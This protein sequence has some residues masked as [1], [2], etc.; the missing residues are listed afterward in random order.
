MKLQN[1]DY[2]G[3]NQ[4]ARRQ[5]FLLRLSADETERAIWDALARV[6]LGVSPAAYTDVEKTVARNW[7]QRTAL[8]TGEGPGAGMVPTFAAETLRELAGLYGAYQ[9]LGVQAAPT[10]KTVFPLVT[11]LPTAQ[12]FT[13]L[14]QGTQLTPGT[15]GGS[16]LS[17]EARDVVSMVQIA[18]GVL[19]DTRV[20]LGVALPALLAQSIAA[21]VDHAAFAADGTD[22]DTDGGMTGIFADGNVGV[23]EAGSATLAE[24]L[25][26]EDF[27]RAMDGV[28]AA[29]LQRGCRWWMHPDIY[30]KVLRVQNGAGERLVR[31][32]EGEPTILGC[33]VTLV[34]AAPGTNAA[35]AKVAAFGCGAGYVVGI[36][37]EF[38][39]RVAE[40][41]PGFDFCMVHLKVWTR[42]VCQMAAADYFRILQLH[43]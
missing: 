41:G 31:F 35:G 29:A 14:T 39:T 8:V 7:P 37:D 4:A 24:D 16:G 1:T 3:T 25:E 32:V 10:G 33:P 20:N 18:R 26:E 34:V 42:A 17:T 40:N 30:R 6:L 19:D 22:D 5:E 2:L 21:A 36:R 12:W 43:A 27:L 38:Y 28:S 11:S 15:I 13:P 9:T 23:A